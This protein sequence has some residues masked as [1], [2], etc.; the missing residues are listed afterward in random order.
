MDQKWFYN[1]KIVIANPYKTKLEKLKIPL[2]KKNYPGKFLG[3]YYSVRIKF[4]IP[5]AKG[6]FAFNSLYP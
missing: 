6:E 5:S 1:T 4:K 3:T 2:A